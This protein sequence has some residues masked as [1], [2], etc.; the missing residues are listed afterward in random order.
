VYFGVQ[1]RKATV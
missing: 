1:L